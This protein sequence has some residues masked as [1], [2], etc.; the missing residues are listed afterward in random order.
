MLKKEGA[1]FVSEAVAQHKLESFGS[2]RGREQ[3][4]GSNHHTPDDLAQR[5]RV[6][7]FLPISR[8]SA[9]ASDHHE[10][11]GNGKG[12]VREWLENG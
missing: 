8:N 10:R 12:M 11:L 7:G 9:F 6:G 3:G 2:C 4:G 1:E 5:S